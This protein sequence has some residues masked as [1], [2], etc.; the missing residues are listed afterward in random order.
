MLVMKRNFNLFDMSKGGGERTP[1]WVAPSGTQAENMHSEGSTHF[2]TILHNMLTSIDNES[3]EDAEIV[4][5]QT[6]GKCFLIKQKEEFTA[7]I[8]SR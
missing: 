5:W 1:P 2:P 3:G 8:L 4:S 7:K 6:H